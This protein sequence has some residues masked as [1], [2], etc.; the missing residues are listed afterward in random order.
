MCYFPAICKTRCGLETCLP[1]E[2]EMKGYMLL[3]GQSLEEAGVHSLP[4]LPLWPAGYGKEQALGMAELHVH[5]ASH[6]SENCGPQSQSLLWAGMG[7]KCE[8]LSCQNSYIW[9]QI[10]HG[11]LDCSNSKR[12]YYYPHFIVKETEAQFLKHI[13]QLLISQLSF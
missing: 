6:H 9:R 8:L 10:E 13:P 5:C 2:C 12:Q 4:S 1:V 3:L 7:V 11:I